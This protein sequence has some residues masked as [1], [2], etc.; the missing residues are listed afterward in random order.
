MTTIHTVTANDSNLIRRATDLR[1]KVWQR[2]YDLALVFTI[3]LAGEWKD[4]GI[5]GIRSACYALAEELKNIPG[6]WSLY[7]EARAIAEG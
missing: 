4:R 6:S 7:T 1:S 3:N 2:H 5:D